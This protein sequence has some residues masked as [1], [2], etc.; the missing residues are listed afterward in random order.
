MPAPASAPAPDPAHNRLIFVHG[1]WHGGTGILARV[2]ALHPDVSAFSGTPGARL[3]AEDEGQHLQ[4]VFPRIRPRLFA[5]PSPEQCCCGSPLECPA[6]LRLADDPEARRQLGRDWARYWDLSR[7]ALLVK[8]PDFSQLFLRA[9]FP[10][11]EGWDAAFVF[12]MRHPFTFHDRYGGQPDTLE[13]TVRAWLALWRR[14]RSEAKRGSLGPRTAVVRLED[15]LARPHATL[16]PVLEA[17]GLDAA[18]FPWDR[19]VDGAG[20]SDARS[21]GPQPQDDGTGRRTDADGGADGASGKTGARRRRRR[22]KVHEAGVANGAVRVDRSYMWT[23]TALRRWKECV[24]RAACRR[25]MEQLEPAVRKISGYSLLDPVH[26][27]GVGRPG[28]ETAQ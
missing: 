25:V 23:D 20:A 3:A 9:M 21:E 10:A 18:A 5:Q 7:R 13:E 4:S 24:A 16:R 28:Y 17:A 6:L 1:N 19:L 14:V 15:L 2:L 8:N 26:E 12:S 27:S 22:L 11:R